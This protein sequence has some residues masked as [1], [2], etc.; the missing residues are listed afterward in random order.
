MTPGF[1]VPLLARAPAPWGGLLF[2][3]LFLA[4][5]FHYA[6][7]ATPRPVSRVLPQPFPL[8]VKRPH[9]TARDWLLNIV[10]TYQTLMA[11]IGVG[12]ADNSRTQIGFLQ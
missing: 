2:A 10:K 7:A 6:H 3:R 8:R 1:R 12:C 11:L 5:S 9:D 4:L